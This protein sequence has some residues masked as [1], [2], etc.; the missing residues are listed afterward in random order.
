MQNGKLERMK[1]LKA[2]LDKASFAY[3]QEAREI[4]SDHEYD[5]L[6]DEL[7]RLEEETGI[8]LAGSPTQKV[9]AEIA[10]SLP[11][12]EHAQPMLSLDKTKSPEE[13]A[14]WL[15]NRIGELSWKLD[16]LTVVLTY[17]NGLLTRAVTRGNGEVGE[18]VTDNA[19]RFI[20][21]P[22]KIPYAGSLVVRGEAVI[23]Y[24]DFEEI[25]SR[26]EPEEQYKN[27]RNLASGSVRLLDSSVTASRR[28]HFIVYTLVSFTEEEPVFGGLNSKMACL[29]R[30]QSFGFEVVPY[31]S[32]TADSLPQT[33]EELSHRVGTEPFPSDGLV[34][35]YDDIAYSATLGR[36][37]KFPRD[38][39]AFKWQDELAETTLL[40]VEWQTSRT[41]LINPV[42]VFE[43]VELEGTTVRRASLHNL[44]IIEELKLGLG[45]RVTV[46]KA[47]MI[48]PQIAENLTGSANLPVPDVC[49][50]CG[51]PTVIEQQYDSRILVCTNPACPAKR[52][53]AFIHFTSRAGMNIEG[54]SEATLERFIDEGFL[55]EFPDLFRLERYR[56]RISALKGFGEKSAEKLLASAEAARHTPAYR[57]VAALG[58]PGVGSAGARAL[59]K[60]FSGSVEKLMDATPAQLAS[61][62]GFADVAA[63]KITAFF[64]DEE[65]RRITNELIGCLDFVSEETAPAGSP[66]EGKTVVITGALAHFRNREE[67]SEIIARAGGKVASAVSSKTDFLINN[68]ITSTSGKNKKARELSIPILSEDEFMERFTIE[69]TI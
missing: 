45:D 43:P 19:R 57:L 22:L 68:D 27:P 39:M 48:I 47:N 46:Y 54:F 59:M 28:V 26:L 38:S 65:N 17:E 33:I 14:A 9:G 4:M 15:G 35:T 55:R 12:V 3:Y 23:S 13:L 63:D 31:F 69:P 52:L 62:E 18:L 30:L 60:A 40:S 41:G 5:A 44:S 10:S 53:D 42:A 1:E 21:V 64:A 7:A 49:P 16:G 34:L 11:K 20:G 6:Y 36:T 51:H 61:I 66:L 67:L 25:N 8:V 50:C 2:L 29:E 56:D 58:I 32:V 37:A 24:R